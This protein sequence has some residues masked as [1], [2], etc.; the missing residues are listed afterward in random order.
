MTGLAIILIGLGAWAF[1]SVY[2]DLRAIRHVLEM[3]QL[4]SRRWWR[5]RV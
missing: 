1:W 2:L 3:K 4:G 5:D